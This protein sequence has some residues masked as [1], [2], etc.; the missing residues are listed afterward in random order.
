MTRTVDEL[1]EELVARTIPYIQAEIRVLDV[2]PDNALFERRLKQLP[3]HIREFMGGMI[4]KNATDYPELLVRY[5][6]RLGEELV[7]QAKMY[8]QS[9]YI[10]G[11]LEAL[12][13]QLM[14]EDGRR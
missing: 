2:I 5:K 4:P 3:E 14:S 10:R 13:Q 6:R 7:N 1:I 12:A 9:L 8:Q 11:S